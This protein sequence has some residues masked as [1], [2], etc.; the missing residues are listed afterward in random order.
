M[1]TLAS[2]LA[3]V[4]TYTMRPDQIARTQQALTNAIIKEHSELDYVEDLAL[5]S[6]ISL[7]QNSPNLFRYS[8]SLVSAGLYPA[9]RKILMIK[10]IP[11][12]TYQDFGTFFGDYGTL[13]FNRTKA[14]DIIDNYYA[15]R[16]NYYSQIGQVINLVADREVDNVGILYY[17]T[18]VVDWSG[19]IPYVDWIADQFPNLYIYAA[20][21]EVFKVIGKDQQMKAMLQLVAETRMAVIKSKIN[22]DT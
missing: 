21:A 11:A 19:G 16:R 20:A 1:T 3:S 9:C 14:S 17:A 18:P 10:E 6:P 7:T 12:H 8:V 15:E 13:V 22:E 2:L 4:F 5:Q